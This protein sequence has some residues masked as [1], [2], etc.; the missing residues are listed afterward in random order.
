MLVTE[1][2]IREFPK[3]F[4]PES[5]RLVHK[6]WRRCRTAT[7]RYKQPLLRGSLNRNRLRY[8]LRLWL[9]KQLRC[10]GLEGV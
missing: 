1:Y 10:G 8:G 7:A 3:L 5:H 6:N 4:S 9:M 2:R